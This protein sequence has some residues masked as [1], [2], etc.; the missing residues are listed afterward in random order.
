MI[1]QHLAQKG[2]SVLFFSSRKEYLVLERGLF[3]WGTCQGHLSGEMS[4]ENGLFQ[5][6]FFL[7]DYPYGG[8]LEGT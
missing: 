6:L 4:K 3:Q 8:I 7:E 2:P 5:K 1:E